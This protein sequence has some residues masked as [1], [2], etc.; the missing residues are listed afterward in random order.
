M[1]TNRN[2]T[3]RRVLV[4][5]SPGYHPDVL[6][7]ALG[8]A[9]AVS[10]TFGGV[11]PR[12]VLL[13]LVFQLANIAL[14]SLAWRNVL[15]AAYPDNRPRLAD[16]ACAYTAGAAVNSVTVARAGDAVKTG[17][18]RARLRG[19][20]LPTIVSS[21]AVTGIFDAFAGATALLLA[22]RLG[23]VDS[24]PAPPVPSVW[25][26]V[27][28]AV[29]LVALAVAAVLSRRRVARYARDLRERTLRGGAV[30][31]QPARYAREVAAVQ[32]LAWATRVGLVFALLSAFQIHASLADALLV[33]VVGGASTVVPSG[34][35]GAGAQQVAVAFALQHTA[36]TTAAVSFSIGMQ[37]GVT[38]VNACLGLLA[39]MILFRT[40]RPDV[41]LRQGRRAATAETA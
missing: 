2:L 4:S 14:R 5:P 11:D 33:L 24:L 12:F 25:L 19:S 17:L 23:A 36:S 7:G 35:G 6:Q 28:G 1:P 38:F 9:D 27:A 29:V 15:C 30:L 34:P 16:V 3:A 18:V 20:A 41:L 32:A 22:W 37:L 8:A 31:R 10:D 40:L 39:G 26:A 21:L 13:A